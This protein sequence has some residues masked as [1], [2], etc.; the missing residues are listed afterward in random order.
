LDGSSAQ[1]PRAAASSLSFGARSSRARIR[2]RPRAR[3]PHAIA[4]SLAFAAAATSIA[5]ADLVFGPELTVTAGE[6]A[7]IT[8][9]APSFAG[10]RGADARLGGGVIVGRGDRPSLERARI[11]NE[12]LASERSRRAAFVTFAGGF[13]I[14]ALFFTAGMRS[15][16]RGKLLRSQLAVL[17]TLVIGLAAAKAAVTLTEVSVLA[18]PVAA[19]SLLALAGVD[20]PSGIVTGLIAGFA[21]AVMVPFDPGVIAVL[22]AQGVTPVL[23][24]GSG[25]ITRRRVALAAAAGGLA[26]ALAYLAYALL[27]WGS[28]P[29]IGT[30]GM[31]A[32]G[33]LT[34]ALGGVLAAPLAAALLAPFQV[35]LGEVTHNRL[36]E[37][38]NFANPLL[39]HIAERSPGTWQHSLAMANM[40]ETAASAI[41]A[42]GR[43]VR[44]GAYYHDLGKSFQPKYFIENLSPGEPSPHDS[45]APEVS[46]RVIFA[47]VSEGVRR[48]RAAGLPERIVDFMHMH[49]GDGILEY[50]WSKCQEQDN[51]GGLTEADFRYPG[52][53]PQ[54]RETAILAITDAVEAASRTLRKADDRSIRNLVQRIVYGK[55]HLGQLDESGLTMSHLRKISEALA[56]T[57]KHA[58]HGRIE[59]PWQRE[60]RAEESAGGNRSEAETVALQPRPP[61]PPSGDPS[62]TT[63]DIRLD[64]LDA[65]G[66][67]WRVETDP[68]DPA[69]FR[70]AQGSGDDLAEV[71]AEN[72]S[73]PSPETTATGYQSGL[74]DG[75][76]AEPAAAAPYPGT[77]TDAGV[78]PPRRRGGPR[79]QQLG[80]WQDALETALPV[81]APRT[82]AS[83]STIEL[84]KVRDDR[85]P[86]D[87]PAEDASTSVASL[88]PGTLVIGPPPETHPGERTIERELPIPAAARPP[89]PERAIPFPDDTEP[90]TAA[91]GDDD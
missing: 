70:P 1:V 68:G 4:L 44:V 17:G 5:A 12:I 36:V 9:R 47:H 61:R 7:P 65:P 62:R 50:F 83:R 10:Y 49:H 66:P 29:T 6:R 28:V 33:P 14:L 64:S 86:L 72:A 80:E 8:V 85:S 52:L 73:E 42:D 57:I 91:I 21:F 27:S 69:T 45:L 26:A 41:G 63:G 67:R 77:T 71:A 78:G 79:T 19:L 88:S 16:H 74:E 23:V 13:F 51:P 25:P 55:L 60:Q 48:G 56:A 32:W 18:M 40:A 34:A 90:A 15:G 53:P 3:W 87:E 54:T 31:L 35:L 89:A 84:L 2:P 81:V 39:Q 22:A 76:A 46:A 75:T 58:H 20:R 37:L 38:E 30:E 24:L 11:A 82:R 43:L 59:Y